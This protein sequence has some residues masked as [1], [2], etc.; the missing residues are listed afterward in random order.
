MQ[1]SK[2]SQLPPDIRDEF[3][4]LLI[5]SGFSGY[6]KWAAWLNV[7]G[8]EIGRSAVG[9]E[10]QKLQRR[11]NAIKVATDSARAIAKASPDDEGVMIDATIRML[12]EKIFNL[13]VEMEEL[14][15]DDI[16]ITKLGRMVA[17]L[18]RAAISQKKWQVDARKKALE[19]AADVVEETARQRGADEEEARF[20]REKVL[21][22]N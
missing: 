15:A 9:R 14:D 12:Q 10:G 6:T 21:G 13:F 17:D 8:Y 1:R 22:V 2:V 20:W 11:L 16:D 18:S 19:D 7:R 5:A 3:E 4:Q